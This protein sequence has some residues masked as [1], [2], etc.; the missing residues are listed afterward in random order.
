MFAILFLCMDAFMPTS[1]I[2]NGVD[3][4]VGGLKTP[5]NRNVLNEIEK[6]GN[7]KLN[8]LAVFLAQYLSC[9]TLF[10]YPFLSSRCYLNGEEFM[11]R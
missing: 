6:R 9:L 5:R 3:S 1:I 11:N 7:E 4:L 10:P 8:S 2:K